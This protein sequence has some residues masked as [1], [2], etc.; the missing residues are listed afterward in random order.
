MP[1]IPS[2]TSLRSCCARWPPCPSPFL[3][4]HCWTVAEAAPEP[5]LRGRHGDTGSEPAP[6]LSPRGGG[7]RP[8]TDIEPAKLTASWA[9]EQ[10]QRHAK[11]SDDTRLR[12]QAELLGVSCCGT[13]TSRSTVRMATL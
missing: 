13:Q 10:L 2:G 11:G 7:R 6:H 4:R 1:P 5:S 3:G 12:L 9:P 8:T